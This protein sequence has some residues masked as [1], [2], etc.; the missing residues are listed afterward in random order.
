MSLWYLDAKV[1]GEV[2][3]NFF[4]S[5]CSFIT[6][7]GFNLLAQNLQEISYPLCQKPCALK[8]NYSTIFFNVNSSIIY[9]HQHYIIIVTRKWLSMRTMK[10][11]DKNNILWPFF[12]Y[13]T[14]IHFPS[15]FICTWR[16]QK[17][18][19]HNAQRGQ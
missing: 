10:H 11:Y 8:N 5:F 7:K 15:R 4:F 17:T 1:C 19:K 12:L 9:T 6:T 13:S 3:K 18:F 16:K 2:V 14:A